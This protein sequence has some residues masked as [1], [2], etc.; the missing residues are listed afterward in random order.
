MAE[1]FLQACFA[2]LLSGSQ[3]H[4]AND[5]ISAIKITENL[6]VGTRRLTWAPLTKHSDCRLHG[7]A[8]ATISKLKTEQLVWRTVPNCQQRPRARAVSAIVYT[9]SVLH[10]IPQDLPTI[11]FHGNLIVKSMPFGIREFW[12]IR[13]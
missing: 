8:E 9:D 7:G 6:R 11:L 4:P 5:K 10:T 2:E 13:A 1:T 12:S 3:E